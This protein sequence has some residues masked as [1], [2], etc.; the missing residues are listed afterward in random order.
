MG[1]PSRIAVVGLGRASWGSWM[2]WAVARRARTAA[3]CSS[4]LAGPVSLPARFAPSAL[5]VLWGMG[6]PTP[7]AW[8]P[9]SQRQTD[10]GFRAPLRALFGRD[11]RMT[12]RLAR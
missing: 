7:R 5:A 6:D 3:R 10:A 12:A 11:T 9:A 8:E 2:R 1:A 4:D